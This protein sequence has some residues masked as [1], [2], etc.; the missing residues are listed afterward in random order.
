[1]ATLEELKQQLEAKLAEVNEALNV[2]NPPS[3]DIVTYYAGEGKVFRRCRDGALCG[4]KLTLGFDYSLGFKRKDYITFYEEVDDPELAT[5]KE[6][7]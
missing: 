6:S 1:M 4:K 5:N 2:Y 3:S 7:E